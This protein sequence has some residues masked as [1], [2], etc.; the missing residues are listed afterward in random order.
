MALPKILA[1]DLATRLGWACGSPD[2]EP[3]YGSKLLP[4]TGPEIGRFGDAYDEWLLDMITLENPA[5]VVF[6]A[7]FVSGTGNA[8]TARKLMGLC[9][10]TELACYRRQIRCMEHGNTS[11]KKLFAGS[12]R[13]EKHEMIAAAQRHGWNPKDDHAADALGLWACAVHEK[14]PKYSR[15]KLGA[16]GAVRAA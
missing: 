3:T 13:A 11:V 16:L 15:L 14:A 9:W 7:P 4:S 5:L 8:N 1:L 10:Q 12:G 2:G 6:E